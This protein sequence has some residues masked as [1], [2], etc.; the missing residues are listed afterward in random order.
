MRWVQVAQVLCPLCD[1]SMTSEHH[2]AVM[3]AFAALKDK[4]RL[5][6]RFSI[7]IDL[8]RHGDEPVG[9]PDGLSG[10]AKGPCVC[11]IL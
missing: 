5:S 8:L 4:Y 9:F 3:R 7:V 1:C 11:G 6:Q 10:G 2:D